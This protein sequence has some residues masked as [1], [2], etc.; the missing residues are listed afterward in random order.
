MFFAHSASAATRT[1][2]GGGSTPW[3]W[4]DS[5]NWDTLPVA[6]DDLVFPAG[7]TNLTTNNNFTAGTVFNSITLSGGGY[8]LAGN[9]VSITTNVADS[10]TSG[11]NI[12]SLI[13]GGT[14]AT[15]SKSGSG[16][17][18][19]LSGNNTFT[20]GVTLSAGTLN[21]NN[22]NAL[23]NGGTFTIS[24]GTID[25]TAGTGNVV[26]PMAW[27]GDFTFGGT[28]GLAF[29]TGAITPNASRT[30]TVN[31]GNVLTISSVIGGGAINLTKTG[32]NF[33]SLTGANTYT[34]TTTILQGQLSISSDVLPGQ[35]GPLGN[36][37][38]DIVLGDVSGSN[39]A[40]L[41]LSGGRTIGR[42]IT[43]QSGSTGVAN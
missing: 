36:S 19:T 2:S 17:V 25:R 42:N 12:I 43:I 9:S 32:T 28:L 6:G 23:G 3:N 13:I 7:P 24:G 34:G 31:G 15:V 33:L 1:W 5:A 16:G 10:N 41:A 38:S 14:G 37:S 40:T 27:N 35:N 39:T 29:S 18:L 8:T 26:N 4:N 21:I 20:G 11:T 30:I 22:A